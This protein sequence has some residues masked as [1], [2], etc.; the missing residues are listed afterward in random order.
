M[1]VLDTDALTVIQRGG[2]GKFEKLAAY[3]DE[4]DD[5]RVTIISFHE[6]VN[7]ALNLVSKGR[8]SDGY[9]LLLDLLHDY[10]ERPILPFDY[11][12]EAVLGAIKRI[13]P[14]RAAMDLRIAAI[15]L[16]HDATL[17]TGNVQ[18][19][20]AIPDLRVHRAW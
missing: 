7:G 5:V 10:C 15:A 18:D 13:K 14:R 2:G 12:A 8:L 3:L 20:E 4:Q 9:R 19:F 17:V 1:H 11:Q 6:Q 16:A